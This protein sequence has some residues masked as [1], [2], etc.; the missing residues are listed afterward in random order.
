MRTENLITVRSHPHTN[1]TAGLEQLKK[2]TFK[3]VKNI[4]YNYPNTPPLPEYLC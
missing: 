2:E 1:K 4:R 3:S